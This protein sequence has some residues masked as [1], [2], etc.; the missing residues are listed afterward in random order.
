VRAVVRKGFS[1]AMVVITGLT[2]LAVLLPLASIVYT[3]AVNGAPALSSVDF[4]TQPPANPCSPG[5]GTPCHYGGI[6][7]AIEG[8]LVLIALAALIAVPIGLGAALYVV[9]FSGGAISGRIISAA[10]DVLSGVPSIVAGL[11]VYSYLVVNDPQ[12]VFSA[13]SGSLALAVL[14]IPIVTRTSEEAL[15]TV[16]H[17]QRE[18]ALAL[19]ISKWKSS[20]RITTV[21]A[22]PGIVTGILLAVAR[23][24]GE[25]APLL[26]TAF[27]NNRGF[28]GLN[29]PV[30]AMPLLIFNFALSPYHNWIVLAWG[31]AL[32]LLL[33]M[34]LLSIASR[35]VLNRL[36]RRMRGEA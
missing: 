1:Y 17:A 18:A 32:V 28:E 3:A 13:I 14:M 9:E 26:L 36:S 35:L 23:A 5:G 11:F 34:L 30:G 25:A 2:L 29:Q 24:G 10:A 6:A 19:G 20:L 16:P 33:I 27:G 4:F 15:R 7:P 31:T 12:I 8:S 21:A 22:L